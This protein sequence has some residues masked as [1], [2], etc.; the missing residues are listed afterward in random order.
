M[1]EL[2][3]SLDPNPELEAVIDDMGQRALAMFLDR[4]PDGSLCVSIEPQNYVKM[5]LRC[6]AAEILALRHPLLDQK[7][8]TDA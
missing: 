4:V 1:T 6:A 2:S 5:A 3:F 8:P 7:G